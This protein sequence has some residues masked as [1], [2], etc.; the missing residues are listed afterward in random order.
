MS[1]LKGMKMN[2]LKYFHVKRK[3]FKRN[4][5]LN[6]MPPLSEPIHHWDIFNNRSKHSPH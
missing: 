1:K 5:T 2:Q 4:N 6:Q 3:D